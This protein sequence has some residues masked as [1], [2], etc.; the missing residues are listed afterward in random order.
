MLSLSSNTKMFLLDTFQLS[1]IL[2]GS[3][4][5]AQHEIISFTSM[6]FFLLNTFHL[7]FI[8]DQIFS[9]TLLIVV[10]LIFNVFVNYLFTCESCLE[11]VHRMST[12]EFELSFDQD[13]IERNSVVYYWK[14]LTAV[15]FGCICMFAF[16]MC[17]RWVAFY[18]FSYLLDSD[19]WVGDAII[20]VCCNYQDWPTLN[21]QMASAFL[22]LRGSC[23][24]TRCSFL[25]AI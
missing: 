17:E 11:R 14:Q 1:F 16:E 20:A 23:H 10:F 19:S 18:Q 3:Y 7:S 6:S 24:A 4:F 13:Q 5:F 25:D 8:L 12:N 2:A 22:N 21:T 15:G 9:Y